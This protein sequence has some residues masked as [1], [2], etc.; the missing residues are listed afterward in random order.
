MKLPA[1]VRIGYRDFDLIAFTETPR[2]E[3]DLPPTLDD[4]HDGH[5]DFRNQTITYRDAPSQNAANTILHE[6]LHVIAGH[7]DV[8][9]DDEDW[10]EEHVVMAFANGLCSLISDN[11]VLIIELMRGLGVAPKLASET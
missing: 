10:L 7:A 6:C 9:A 8:F 5:T 11:P 4:E 2:S 1:T 3:A